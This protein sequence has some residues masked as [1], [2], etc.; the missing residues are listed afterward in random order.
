MLLVAVGFSDFCLMEAPS[1]ECANHHRQFFLACLPLW[2]A[3]RHFFSR[4]FCRGR[5]NQSPPRGPPAVPTAGASDEGLRKTLLDFTEKHID[6]GP[7]LR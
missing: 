6:Q 5:S 1:G 7:L 2:P 4:N 3:C